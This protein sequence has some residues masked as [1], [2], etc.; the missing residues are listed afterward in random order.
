MRNYAEAESLATIAYI[1]NFEF[2]EAPL[3]EKDE[4]LMENT[5]IMLRE[6]LRQLIQSRVPAEQLQQHL[7]KINNNLDRAGQL[8]GVVS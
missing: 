4:T 3:E 7:D 5:E 1:D 2:I 6:L 8:L